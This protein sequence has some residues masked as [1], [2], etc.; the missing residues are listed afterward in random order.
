VRHILL[1]AAGHFEELVT[2]WEKHHG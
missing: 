2:L 1:A